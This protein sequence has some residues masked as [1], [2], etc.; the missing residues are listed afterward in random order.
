MRVVFTVEHPDALDPVK[1]VRIHNERVQVSVKEDFV[2]KYPEVTSKTFKQ[3][4][5]G[6]PF[7]EALDNDAGAAVK[8][9]TTDVIRW[10]FVDGR[11]L[12]LESEEYKRLVHKETFNEGI[13]SILKG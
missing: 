1:K 6:Y 9:L 13:E 4:V 7:Y 5:T 3:L 8:S 12:S 11:M 2:K 10:Y